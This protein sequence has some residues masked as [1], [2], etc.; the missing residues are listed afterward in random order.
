MHQV[1]DVLLDN[2][3]VVVVV[4]TSDMALMIFQSS[5]ARPGA[6]TATLVCWARPSVFTYVLHFSVYAAA[7]RMTSAIGAPKSP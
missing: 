5:L 4:F 3:N 2:I 7:G 6:V 1:I